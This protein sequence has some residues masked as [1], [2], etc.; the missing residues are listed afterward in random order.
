MAVIQLKMASIQQIIF[1]EKI[2]NKLGCTSHKSMLSTIFIINV[3][4]DT[5]IKRPTKGVHKYLRFLN[6]HHRKHRCIICIYVCNYLDSYNS[7]F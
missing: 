2:I 1:P 5:I 7:A 4:S 6:N 3:T